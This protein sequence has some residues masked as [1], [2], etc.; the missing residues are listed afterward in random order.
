MLAVVSQAMQVA[1]PRI[2]IVLARQIF[3]LAIL[4]DDGGCLLLLVVAN[5]L[6]HAITWRVMALWQ[7]LPARIV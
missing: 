4:L 1:L 3:L 2:R 7:E 5:F 6:L